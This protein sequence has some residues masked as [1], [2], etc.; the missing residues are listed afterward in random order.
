V[1]SKDLNPGPPP[2]RKYLE[3][4]VEHILQAPQRVPSAC[5]R[6]LNLLGPTEM[7]YGLPDWLTGS[8]KPEQPASVRQKSKDGGYIAPD[9]NAR[10][11]CYE[12]RDLFFECLDKHDILDAVKHDAEARQKCPRENA[13]YERDCARSWVRTI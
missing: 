7:A 2:Q 4:G 5:W 8:P 10:E 11:L 12:S 1:Y 9:R 13:E 3:S 6:Q